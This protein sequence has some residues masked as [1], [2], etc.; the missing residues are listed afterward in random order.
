MLYI[1]GWM[2][3]YALS[4]YYRP[5]P[6]LDEWIRRRV[7]MCYMKQWRRTRTR[8]RNLLNLGASRTQAIPV[9]LSSKGPWRLART[10]ASQLGMNNAWL[11]EQ[12]LVSVRDLWIAFH[13]PNG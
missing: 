5:L 10:Y 9:G 13:Y 11:K 1:R 12:G 3:Y 8:I 6:E 4:E 7:R 2:N